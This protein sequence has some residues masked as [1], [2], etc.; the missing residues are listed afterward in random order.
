MSL[1]QIVVGIDFG[2]THSGVSWAVKV[3]G[4]EPKIRVINDWPSKVGNGTYDKVP[5]S[6]SYSN[7]EVAEWGYLSGK[8]SFTWFK[9]FLDPDN[10]Y[11]DSN[12][13]ESLKTMLENTKRSA[14]DIAGDYLR[15]LW[16]YT[17]E[18][19]RRHQ[20]DGWKSIYSFRVVLTVPAIW[21]AVAKE[22]TLRAAKS[23]GIPGDIILV[24]EPEAAALAVLKDK[25]EEEGL[26]IKEW[27]VGDGGLCGVDLKGVEDNDALGIEDDNIKLPVTMFDHTC[28]QIQ[29]IVEK[30]IDSVR[31]RGDRVN[32]VLLVGGFGSSKYLHNHLSACQKASNIRVLQSRNYYGVEVRQRFDPS[33]H[34]E[35]DR[36]YDNAKGIHYARR[37]MKW[38]LQRGGEMK[39][40][41]QMT[42]SVFWSVPVSFWDRG[43]QNFS[44]SLLVC[45]EEIAPPRRENNIAGVAVTQLCTINYSV[46]RDELRADKRYKSDANNHKY[47]DATF[48]LKMKLGGAKLDFQAYYKGKLMA[49]CE[50]TYPEDEVG[51]K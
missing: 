7:G 1:S 30:Q 18:D 51:V 37:Q 25:A 29:A 36:H 23:A 47:R 3:K 49:F 38:L 17:T 5:T 26:Q 10:T 15:V 22:R 32:A 39:D 48:E 40:E 12:E 35:S 27:I 16:N 14:E 41:E 6:I 24:T 4:R 31:E 13:L 21:S 50:A 42:L 44:S 45:A 43:S 33:V 28:N 20:G 9:L 11:K 46:A 2:T 34:H 19:I 8:D